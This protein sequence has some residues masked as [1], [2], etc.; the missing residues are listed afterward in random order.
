MSIF[1]KKIY[2]EV[3]HAFGAM[4]FS[5]VLKVNCVGTTSREISCAK[6]G[7]KKL[8]QLDPSIIEV[9]MICNQRYKPD[10][11]IKETNFLIL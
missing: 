10:R 7:T 1:S 5:S 3:L 8:V 2:S 6:S 11:K 4:S 9:N